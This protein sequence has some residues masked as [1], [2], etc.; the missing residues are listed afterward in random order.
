MTT[1]WIIAIWKILVIVAIDLRD[2]E[3]IL[4]ATHIKTIESVGY[5]VFFTFDIFKLWSK[6]FEYYAPTH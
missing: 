5:D 1:N 2:V 4:I 3:D 6:L